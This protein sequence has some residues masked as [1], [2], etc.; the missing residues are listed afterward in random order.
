MRLQKNFTINGKIVKQ[1]GESLLGCDVYESDPEDMSE[2]TLYFVKDDNV[3]GEMQV[4]ADM[5]QGAGY[6]SEY[7]FTNYTKASVKE[8]K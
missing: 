4:S 5:C 1:S 6:I 8:E 3:V 2:I 7:K